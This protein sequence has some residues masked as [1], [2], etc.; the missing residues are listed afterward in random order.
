MLNDTIGFPKDYQLGNNIL[1]NETEVREF[2][3][4]INGKQPVEGEITDSRS[5]KF[6]AHRC[7]ENCFPPVPPDQEC[8]FDDIRKWSDPKGWDPEPEVDK[9]SDTV[10]LPPAAGED[11]VIPPGWNM[12]FD[13][14]ESPIFDKIE[15]NGCLHFKMGTDVHLNAKKILI[16]GGEFYIGTSDARYT[17]DGKITLHGGRNEPTIAIEDQGIEAGSKIIANIGKLNFYGK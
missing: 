11:V 8:Q 13:L 14:A 1:Y 17:N 12:E 15:V 4:I 2:H 7:V 9:R 16:R 5:M 6:V 3:F 10:K